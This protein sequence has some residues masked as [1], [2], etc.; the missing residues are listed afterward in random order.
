VWWLPGR[1]RFVISGL[2]RG[3]LSGGKHRGTQTQGE[4]AYY[5]DTRDIE[6]FSLGEFFFHQS[7]VIDIDGT[8]PV[9]VSASGVCPLRFC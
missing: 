9:L 2:Y 7:S 6:G 8:L 3:I 5:L 1:E 4:T